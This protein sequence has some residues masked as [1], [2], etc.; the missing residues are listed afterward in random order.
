MKD[1]GGILR[2]PVIEEAHDLA[3]DEPAERTVVPV[4]VE[5]RGADGSSVEVEA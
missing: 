2:S 5:G 4:D 1:L 3:I